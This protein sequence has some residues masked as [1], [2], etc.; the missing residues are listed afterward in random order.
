MRQIRRGVFETN[1]SSCHSIVMAKNKL[2]PYG[3]CDT[4]GERGWIRGSALMYRDLLFE[5]FEF[6]V[7]TSWIDK[8]GYSIAASQYFLR[9][10]IENMLEEH[11]EMAKKHGY[12]I[13]KI[14]IEN[15]D[16]EKEGFDIFDFASVDHQSYD[17]LRDFLLENQ[18]GVE[19]FIFDPK[20]VLVI[21]GDCCKYQGIVDAV[22][23][24]DFIPC[25][26]TVPWGVMAVGDDGKIEGEMYD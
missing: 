2:E 14:V 11:V 25:K 20:Y 19:D 26:I 24:K 23:S 6:E 4:E 9:E 3:P 15:M 22:A 10:D 12:N 5:A 21:A 13:D 8:L 7:L 17:L 16:M 1:S 18:I